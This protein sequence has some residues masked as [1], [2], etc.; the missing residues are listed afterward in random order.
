MDL[1]W[2]KLFKRYVWHDDRTPYLT[3]VAN[4]TRLQAQY[5]LFGYAL[6]MAVLFGALSVASLSSAL[7]H[8]GAAVVSIYA[9]TVC[10]AAVLLGATR[11]PWAA[12]WCA[13]APLA[14]L[15]Y[16]GYWGFHP[17]LE[18]GDKALL[19][20]GVIGWQLYSRRVVA[21]A[22]AWQGLAGPG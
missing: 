6:L 18:I 15:A 3:R 4:L 10:C 16:F 20:A 19:V 22:R 8:G 11:H 13:G 2:D 1:N 5:E 14:V 12:M 9:L 17:S 7:P 21:V